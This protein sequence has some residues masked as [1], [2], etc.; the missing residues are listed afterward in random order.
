MVNNS[1]QVEKDLAN[2]KLT[3]TRHFNSPVEDV[4]R[5]WTESELLDKWWAPKP[6]RAETKTMS[7]KV[8]GQWLYAMVG[9]DDSRQWC[10]VEYKAIDRHKSYQAVDAFCDENGNKNPDFP[11]MSWSNSFYSTTTGTKVIVEITF[12]TVA[13]MEKI[14]EMGLEEGFSMALGN[15]DELFA[16]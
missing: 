14:L 16:K 2:R 5:A 11:S 7:F 6:Y 4:W 9:P 12:A 13:D 8:G 15:L 3:V 10:K 1:M